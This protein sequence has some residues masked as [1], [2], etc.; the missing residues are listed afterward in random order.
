MSSPAPKTPLPSQ[1]IQDQLLLHIARA[2]QIQPDELRGPLRRPQMVLARFTFCWSLQALGLNPAQIARS[3]QR[4]HST[5]IHA[6]DRMRDETHAEAREIGRRALTRVAAADPLEVV[7]AN[8]PDLLPHPQERQAVLAYLGWSLLG[9]HYRPPTLCVLGL[10]LLA[11]HRPL[12]RL[13][14]PILIRYD[15]GHHIPRIQLHAERLGYP[16][17]NLAGFAGGD[18]LAYPA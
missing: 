9:R 16:I 13:I 10:R 3:L 17:D 7:A 14:L 6:L 8:L 5:V 4:N 12:R 1:E 15:L 2:F 18:A 11:A